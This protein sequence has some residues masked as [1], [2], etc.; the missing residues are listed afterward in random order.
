MSETYQIMVDDILG[1]SS[2]NKIRN[3]AEFCKK[4]K[5]FLKIFSQPGLVSEGKEEL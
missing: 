4:K 2:D 5:I 1:K 3:R